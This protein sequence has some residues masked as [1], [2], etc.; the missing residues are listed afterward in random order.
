MTKSKNPTRLQSGLAVASFIVG[1]V[2]G[3]VALF[4][5]P[6]PGEITNSAL[7]LTSEFLILCGALLGVNVAF[8]LKMNKFRTEIENEIKSHEQE[9]DR[10]DERDYAQE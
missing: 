5:V 9:G 4:V 7:G 3:C 8:D 2:I 6:P 1:T 10:E